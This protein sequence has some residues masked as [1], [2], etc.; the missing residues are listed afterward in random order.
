MK[1]ILLLA[2]FLTSDAFS[3]DLQEIKLK[4][5]AEKGLAQAEYN[6]ALYFELK[7]A[8]L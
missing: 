2:L 8:E 5:L 7:A 3:A 6:L 1:Y 4:E